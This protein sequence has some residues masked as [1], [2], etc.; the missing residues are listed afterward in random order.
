M[1]MSNSMRMELIY[2]L[3]GLDHTTERPLRAYDMRGAEVKFSHF[4]VYVAHKDLL[5]SIWTGDE[6]TQAGGITR[7]TGQPLT[8]EEEDT[9]DIYLIFY[10]IKKWGK[11]TTENWFRDRGIEIKS[12]MLTDKLDELTE[13]LIQ[14][15]SKEKFNA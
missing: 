13:E 5:V 1:L 15:C 12:H 9:V 7:I 10:A 14:K 2:D 11:R 4:S 8:R 3:V 6:F